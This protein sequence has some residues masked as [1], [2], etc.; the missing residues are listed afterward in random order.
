MK[1][2]KKADVIIQITLIAA[3]LVVNLIRQG[4]ILGEL[5][6][7]SYF[8]VGGWQITSVII[9]FIKPTPIKLVLRKLYLILLG[10]TVFAGIVIGVIAGDG[11]IMFLLGLL[12]VSPVMAI[13]YLITCIKENEKMNFL[14]TN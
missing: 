1:K 4:D 14:P 5:F 13:L 2:F 6:L 10:I 7:S 9:H 8:I 12:F 3:A 11:I